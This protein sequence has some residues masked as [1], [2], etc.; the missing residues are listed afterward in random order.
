MVLIMD[1]E[2]NRQSKLKI[3]SI[4]GQNVRSEREMRR[5]SRDELAE[6]MDLT[7]SHMGLIERGERGATAVT[8]KKLSQAFKV[9]IDS[10]FNQGEIPSLNI[11][12]SDISETAIS[13]QK[14]IASLLTRLSEPELDFVIHMVKGI[15]ALRHDSEGEGNKLI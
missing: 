8:L 2:A 13:T 6:I 15:I 14:R 10:F 3:D 7:V 12:E 5:M 1:R 9:P 4:I 11:R